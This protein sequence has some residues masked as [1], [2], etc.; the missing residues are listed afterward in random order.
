MGLS[1]HGDLHGPVRA[2]VLG[3][4]AAGEVTTQVRGGRVHDVD[5]WA[6]DHQFP[7]PGDGEKAALWLTSITHSA[8]VGGS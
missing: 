1:A 6:L 4:Q 2:D 8:L 5:S 7:D 3:H